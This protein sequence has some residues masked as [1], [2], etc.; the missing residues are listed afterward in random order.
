MVISTLEQLRGLAGFSYLATPYSKYP[1]GLDAAHAMACR[2]AAALMNRGHRIFCPIAHSHC[3]GVAG[4][5]DNRDWD[6]W[7]R[8]DEPMMRAANG[9][10]VVKME[11][12]EES[13]GVTD[14]IAAFEWMGRAIVYTDPE[15]LGL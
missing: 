2:A 6:F 3:I 7:R 10:V 13:V 12:W 1:A 14:E 9:M 5:L 4:H 8:Q 15:D 11:G